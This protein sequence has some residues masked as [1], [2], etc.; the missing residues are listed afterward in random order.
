MQE[1]C[2]QKFSHEMEPLGWVEG[3]AGW[4][5]EIQLRAAGECQARGWGWVAGA[6]M[7]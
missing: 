7:G 1:K 3:L 6:V 5:L 2:S 4:G